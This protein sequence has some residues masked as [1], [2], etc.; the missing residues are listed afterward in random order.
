MSQEPNVTG[1]KQ[2]MTEMTRDRNDPDLK[3]MGAKTSRTEM[4]HVQNVQGAKCPWSEIT[5]TET[6]ND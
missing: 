6:S 4:T 3:S 5:M 2:P 1:Q